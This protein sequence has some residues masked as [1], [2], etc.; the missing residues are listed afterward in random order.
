M[1]QRYTFEKMV[2]V[3][4]REDH[5][6]QLACLPFLY[7]LLQLLGGYQFYCLELRGEKCKLL[8]DL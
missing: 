8:Q 4:Q 2:L 1:V 6:L 5:G 3:Y 7:L